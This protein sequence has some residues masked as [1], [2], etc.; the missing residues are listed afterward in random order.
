VH[1]LAIAAA[2]I[3]GADQTAYTMLR[4]FLT[5]RG[6]RPHLMLREDMVHLPVPTLFAW[7]D[8]DAFAPP[9]SGQEMA[10]RM[11]D[12]RIQVIPDA[13]HLPWYDR[14]HT[15]ATAISGFL[16]RVPRAG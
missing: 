16:A 4:A 12:A 5:I 1:R 13:G 6:L 3:P 2:A 7:G 8:A 10:A 9:S 14:P 11:P 15:V